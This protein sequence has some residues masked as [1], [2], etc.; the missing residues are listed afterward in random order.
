[1]TRRDCALATI[2]LSIDPSL[3][4]IIGDPKDPVTV[5]ELLAGQFQKATWANKLALRRRLHS[6]RLKEGDSVQDHVKAITE[7]F[8]ELSIIGD[9]VKDED[10]VVYLLASLPESYDMLVTALEANAE[11]P[12]MKTVTERLLHEE[13]KI[14]DRNGAS[15]AKEEALVM[16]QNKRGPRCHFCK[17]FGH[18]QRNCPKRERKPEGLYQ[19]DKNS[20]HRVYS[21]K[22]KTR[23]AEGPDSSSEEI[24]LVVQHA[25]STGTES[26][27][28]TTWIVD[29]GATCHVCN[30]RSSFVDLYD[31]EKPLDVTLGDGHTLK[32]TARGTVV[33][34]MKIGQLTRRCKLHDVLF[35]PNL[36]YN[37]ISVSKAVEK[38]ISVSFNERGCIL[39]DN[40]QR[41]IT[42]AEKVGSLYHVKYAEQKNHICSITK[43][44]P[45]DGHSSKEELWHRRYGHLGFKSLQKLAKDNLVTGFDY[46]ATTDLPFCEPCLEGKL[47]RSPYS[48]STDKTTLE[49]LELIHSDVCG[50]MSSK[51]LGGAQYFVTFTDDKTRYVWVYVIKKKSDVFKCFCEWKKEVEKLLG[52]SVKILRTDNGGEFTSCEFEEFLRK[53]GIKHELTIP[54]CP[55]Q[56]GVAER[57]NR[58]LV[59][60]VRSMLADSKLPKSFWAEALATATYVLL[61]QLMGKPLLKPFIV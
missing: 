5:W 46:C 14:K 22:A 61:K 47:H 56:N 3:L 53:E 39:K 24:G 40:K 18:I 41:L 35:V 1:M 9:N 57:L 11:V 44:I 15:V 12:D 26:S 27:P 31:L 34:T 48:P 45:R 2:V 13:R 59:E 30:E 51:S 55:E 20:K 50:K 43:S 7:I 36:S 60:M 32:A 4:Y 42:V 10:R 23:D 21:T 54:K 52:R 29:S 49:P 6:L 25:L 19:R 17:K 33:L 37:L 28:R 16:H 58:T 38:G 8:N